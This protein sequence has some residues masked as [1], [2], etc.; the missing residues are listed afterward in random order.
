MSGIGP[1]DVGAS[2]GAPVADKYYCDYFNFLKVKNLKIRKTF[3]GEEWT[4]C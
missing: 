4:A 1:I 3:E 2:T